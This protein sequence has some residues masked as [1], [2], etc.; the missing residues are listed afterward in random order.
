MK[1]IKKSLKMFEDFFYFNMK[2]SKL[3]NYLTNMC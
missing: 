2:I 1:E 3:I